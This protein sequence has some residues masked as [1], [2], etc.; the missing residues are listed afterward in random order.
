MNIPAMLRIRRQ[1][2]NIS[3]AE[4]AHYIGFKSKS[5]IH[6]LENGRTDWTVRSLIRACEILKLELKIEVLG[7]DNEI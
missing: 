2:L 6:Y 7:E 4:L 5:S 1:E 3:Q